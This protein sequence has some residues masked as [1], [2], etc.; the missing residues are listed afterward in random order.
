M[1]GKIF[2]KKQQVFKGAVVVLGPSKAG[3]TT[4]VR[5]LETEEVVD[6]DPRTTLGIDFRKQPIKIDGVEFSTIDVGGQK[7][8]ADAF[9]SM[10]IEQA[11]AII[12]VIDG[13]VRP[14]DTGNFQ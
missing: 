6:E 3:K 12:F 14:E 4:L 5:Y 7:L 13:L 11:N 10:A 1:L 2:R 9:W 8:Y